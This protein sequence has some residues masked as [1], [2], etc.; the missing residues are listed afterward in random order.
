MFYLKKKQK[1]KQNLCCTC[2]CNIENLVSST[3]PLASLT[4]FQFVL[5]FFSVVNFKSDHIEWISAYW[6]YININI[7]YWVDFVTLRNAIFKNSR[8]QRWYKR[9][10]EQSTHCKHIWNCMSKPPIVIILPF[11]FITRRLDSNP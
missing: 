5:E 1:N 10:R 6:E 3:S 8:E 7:C 2:T 4:K 9:S 11:S